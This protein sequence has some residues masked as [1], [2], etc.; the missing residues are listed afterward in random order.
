MIITPQHNKLSNKK[1]QIKTIPSNNNQLHHQL[2]TFNFK[3]LIIN[4]K[5]KNFKDRETERWKLRNNGSQNKKKRQKY[6]WRM[7]RRG[8]NKQLLKLLRLLMLQN[9]LESKLSCKNK[10]EPKL[11][12][13]KCQHNINHNRIYMQMNHMA[14]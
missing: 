1:W 4:N 6:N 14:N 7:S 10:D 5:K 11:K 2:P 13:Q 12:A 9:Q 8:R 3:V